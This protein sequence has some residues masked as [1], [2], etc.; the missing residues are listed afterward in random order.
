MIKLTFKHYDGKTE[1]AVNADP[2][3][4]ADDLR[5]KLEEQEGLSSDLLQRLVFDGDDLDDAETL[6]EMGIEEGSTILIEKVSVTV[7]LPTKK[8]FRIKLA[9]DD[10]HPSKKIKKAALKKDTSLVLESLICR[11][12]GQ[13]LT[14]GTSMGDLQL[15]HEDTVVCDLYAV[16]VTFQG[17]AWS[18]N[19]NPKDTIA[20]LKETIQSKV[21]YTV[22]FSV[23]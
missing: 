11:F 23:S 9:P 2:T 21:T 7:V 12:D 15:G 19:V 4:Y 3:W 1:Y 6:E 10:P 13:E 22:L 14:D 18:I 5:D 17:D 8:V 20:A 16:Q